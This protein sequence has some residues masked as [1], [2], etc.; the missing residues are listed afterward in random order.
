MRAWH[1]SGYSKVGTVFWTAKKVSD[2]P[3][4][5]PSEKYQNLSL[6]IHSFRNSVGWCNG[7]AASKRALTEML[8]SFGGWIC[9]AFAV[10]PGGVQAVRRCVREKESAFE[11]CSRIHLRA[12]CTTLRKAAKIKLRKSARLNS[13]S[14]LSCPFGS[15][16]PVAPPSRISETSLYE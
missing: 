5:F 6:P 4:L 13:T 10:L 7:A 15:S 8:V 3:V 2:S 9:D 11:S 14:F 1:P 16:R 12:A